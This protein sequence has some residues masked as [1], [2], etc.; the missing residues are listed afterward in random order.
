[1]QSITLT[2]PDISCAHCQQ[3]VE[4]ELG[5]VPGVQSVSVDVPAKRVDVTYD[6]ARTS[7]T[8]IVARLDEAG[9]PVAG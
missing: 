4:R 9:Y 8:E 3:T 5:G 1:M 6:P 7:E 2:A